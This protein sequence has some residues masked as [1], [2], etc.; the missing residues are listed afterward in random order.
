MKRI[1]LMRH[2]K[3]SWD[4]PSLEDIERPL[5]KRGRRAGKAMADHLKQAAI[6]PGMVLCSTSVRTRQTL[7]QMMKALD[8]VDIRFDDRIYDAA[9]QTLQ[10]LLRELPDSCDS[11]LVIGHNPGLERLALGLADGRGDA[12]AITRISVKYPTG[13][14]ACLSAEIGHWAELKA[15]C[16]V[17]DAF[18]CPIDL[19]DRDGPTG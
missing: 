12:K 15:G 4:D 5:N 16:A 8:G 19:E 10:A 9:P 6:R 7:E 1:F 18:T 3:S 17:L 11:V 14:L 13:A 2:A